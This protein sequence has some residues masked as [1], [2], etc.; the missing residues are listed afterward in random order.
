[1]KLIYIIN[2]KIPNQKAHGYQVCKMCEEFA[3]NNIKVELWISARHDQIEQDPFMFYGLWTADSKTGFRALC[4]MVYQG[5][6][7]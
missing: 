6:L 3:R 1:M 7:K 4:F 5:I 2:A